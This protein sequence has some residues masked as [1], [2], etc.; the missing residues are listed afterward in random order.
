MGGSGSYVGKVDASKLIQKLR[1]SQ[2]ETSQQEF[3]A[4]V[5]SLLGSLLNRFNDR[6]VDAINAHLEDIKGALSEDIDGTVN[7]LFGGSVAKHTY[8][9]ISS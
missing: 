8:M 4:E 3:D 5:A 6:P 1:D 2:D 7:L 9:R